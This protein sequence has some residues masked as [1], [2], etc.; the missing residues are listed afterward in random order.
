MLA[1]IVASQNVIQ[2][3]AHILLG[4]VGA[5]IRDNEGTYYNIDDVRHSQDALAE[6]HTITI[7]PELSTK[8]IVLFNSLTFHRLEVVTFFV[9][10]PFIQ[11]C[12]KV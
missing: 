1:A 2:Q 7:G 8:K 4:G 3:C 10:T 12:H 9:S 5:E 6:R 11:V